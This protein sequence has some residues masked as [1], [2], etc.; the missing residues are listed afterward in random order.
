MVAAVTLL[1][2]LL[3]V[4]TE[5]REWN[6]DC[7]EADAV[8]LE[9]YQAARKLIMS[10]PSDLP[11]PTVGAD[12]DGQLTLEWYKTPTRSVSISVNSAGFLHYANPYGRT[13]THGT[14][15]FNGTVPNELIELIEDI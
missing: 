4:W 1:E 7:Y 15:P 10:F 2:E 11:R 3:F 8:T 6:W 5:C 12:P 9:N 13:S 14:I